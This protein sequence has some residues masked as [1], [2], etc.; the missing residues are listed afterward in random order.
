MKVKTVPIGVA[1]T[2][3]CDLVDQVKKGVR[4][5]ITTHGRPAAL[6]GPVPSS[7]VP[8]RVETPDDPKRYGDLQSPVLEPWK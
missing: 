5:V 1:R 2:N 8:W 3:L 7:A 4:I 6:L